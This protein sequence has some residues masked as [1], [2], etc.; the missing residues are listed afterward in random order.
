MVK[1]QF[2]N[3]ALT[4]LAADV[5]SITATTI[6]VTS[7]TDFPAEP[8]FR[9]KINA[10]LML[11]TAVSP[12][13]F[14]VQRGIENTVAA[15]HSLGDDVIHILTA[16]SF[17]VGVKEKYRE[18]EAAYGLDTGFTANT[19]EI[20][21][22]P[23]LTEYTAGLMVSFKSNS[24]NTEASTLN[25]NG[26]GA[27]EIRK[28]GTIALRGGEIN[29]AQVITVVYD[30]DG[31]Q[32]ITNPDEFARVRSDDGAADY[33][34]EKIIAGNG[35]NVSVD[36][37]DVDDLK[38]VIGLA[39]AAATPIGDG[40]FSAFGRES[41]TL[42]LGGLLSN[43]DRYSIAADVWVHRTGHTPREKAVG[44]SFSDGGVVVYGDIGLV[45]DKY[46]DVTDSWA[47]KANPSSP[48]KTDAAGFPIGT[49]KGN[50]VG[51]FAPGPCIWQYNVQ[52]NNTTNSW[53]NRAIL[54][55]GLGRYGHAAFVIDDPAE[56]YIVGGINESLSRT[57]RLDKYN[58]DT[59]TWSAGIIH[60]NEA[61]NEAVAFSDRDN[62]AMYHNGNDGTGVSGRANR[63]NKIINSWINDQLV[64]V[65]VQNAAAIDS[66]ASSGNIFGGNTGDSTD[67]RTH[68]QA[69]FD[70]T[71]STKADIPQP[72]RKDH[73]SF[74]L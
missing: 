31:F 65:G 62:L 47:G 37:T 64:S 66:S 7:V 51:G 15:F 57:T 1:E 46:S 67:V 34:E 28:N 17:D 41:G 39:A 5:T 69:G 35:I 43:L 56:G 9:I 16:E 26:L 50:V 55:S 6:I 44:L 10:E 33:L 25:I 22:V 59:N 24:T 49:D 23:E 29:A 63:F 13:A 72:G 20:D 74:S 45:T 2:S 32:L 12:V 60:G 42:G 27:K 54:A 61:R 73:S 36:E 38:L 18:N 52:Y 30:G 8:Q 19:F 11:V 4:T 70:F 71:Y 48:E 58:N 40:I 3:S 14:V 53:S 68:L 21:L